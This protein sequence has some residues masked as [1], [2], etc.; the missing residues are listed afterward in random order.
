MHSGIRTSLAASLVSLVSCSVLSSQNVSVLTHPTVSKPITFAVTP[1]LRELIK[2]HPLILPFG[3]RE[4]NPVLHPKPPRF[5]QLRSGAGAKFQDSVAQTA[6]AADGMPTKMLD[7]LGLGSDFYGY[8]VNIVP[9]DINSSIGDTQIIQWGNNQ[10]AVFDLDGNNLLFDNQRYVDGN[11]LFANLPR[12]R[13]SNNGDPIAQWDKIAHR[14]V[15]LQPAEAPPARDCIAVSQTADALGPWYAYEFATLN[16]D[17]DFPDYGKLGVWPDAYYVSHND[18]DQSTRIFK[19]TMPCAYERAKL[20]AGD[21]TAQQ[22]CFL[23]STSNGDWATSFDDNQLPSDLDSPN[24]PPPS[25]MPNIYVGSIANTS[26]GFVSNIY[27]YKFHVDW[28][29]PAN[30]TFSCIDGS[31]AIPVAQ[32]YLGSWLGE[33]PEPG[34]AWLHTLAD[35][36]MYRLAYRLLPSPTIG[37]TA[38]N[39]RTVQS[40]LVSHAVGASGHL[41]VRWYEFRAPLGSTDPSVYQQGTYS[42]DSSWRFM[43]SIAM[44]KMGNIAMSYTVTDGTSIYPSIAFTGR[45]KNDPLGTMGPEQ[46]VIAGTGSQVD[47]DDRWGDYYDMAIS[48]DGCT[49]I[50]TGQYYTANASYHWSTRIAKLKFDNCTP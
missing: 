32:F 8:P 44:D 19:G 47:S 50:T 4:G 1:P 29:N 6:P 48:N 38:R 31:C 40:W 20:L 45:A 21:P 25:G 16:P 42:P 33:A 49:F 26:T 2:E 35:T 43:S 18:Y 34:G 36:L 27:Y 28:D 9:S 41:G 30:S 17:T 12:C 3:Y 23:D 46:L 11:I 5:S 14:W 7:W 24:S 37:P 22:V 13:L 15:M 10:F 39:P